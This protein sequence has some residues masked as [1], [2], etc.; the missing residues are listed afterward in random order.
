[1][2]KIKWER[3][4]KGL[5]SYSHETRKHGVNYDRC[6]R[7]RYKIDKKETVIVFG[8]ESEW[9]AGEKARR[10]ATGERGSRISFVDFCKGELLRLKDNARKGSGPTTI[11]E[12]RALAEIQRKEEDQARVAEERESITF[13]TYFNKIYLPIATTHKK[14]D[15]M[16]EE[17]SVFKVWLKPYLGK[18]RLRDLSPLHLEKL[19][20]IMLKDGKSPRR[21]QYVLA[22]SRQVWNTARNQGSVSGDWP[23]RGVKIPKIDNRRMRFLSPQ[24]SEDLLSELKERSKQTHNI[25]LVSLDCGLRFGEIVKIQFGHVNIAD[26]IIMVVDPKGVKNRAAFMTTRVKEMFQ[27]MPTGKK[28]DLVFKD[29]KGEAI[30]K[31]SKT[32]SRAVDHLL[33]N[34]GVIDRRDRVVYHTA[35]HT[36]ASNLV[37]NGASLY[38]VSQLLGHADIIMASRYS[39]LGAGSL[40]AAVEKMEQATAKKATADVIPL[41]VNGKE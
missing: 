31:I 14:T 30:K 16:K 3:A 39:H 5:Q 19:K 25:F 36:F 13:G 6:F 34:D 15:T 22:I 29:T 26:G 24:E 2:G 9:V 7:G 21:I 4:G 18:I 33:L 28:T 11:K 32:F 40:R 27:F 1:M 8:W 17:K 23:G 35:R 12:E 38:V 37:S 20:R 10:K 41:T